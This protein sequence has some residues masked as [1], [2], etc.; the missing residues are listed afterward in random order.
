[1]LTDKLITPPG[2]LFP[3]HRKVCFALG[4]STRDVPF[5]Y[6]WVRYMAYVPL[7]PEQAKNVHTF[8]IRW[9]SESEKWATRFARLN[10]P[11]RNQ[12]TNI[13]QAATYF[14]FAAGSVLY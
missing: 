11:S 6:D 4:Q 14:L 2:I 3:V 7:T 9:L 1:M 13:V 8:A 12:P 10:K 5:G